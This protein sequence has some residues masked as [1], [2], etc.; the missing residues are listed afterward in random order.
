M[1]KSLI[2]WSL[3]VVEDIVVHLLAILL[4]MAPSS[5]VLVHDSCWMF[6]FYNREINVNQ[7]NFR[8]RIHEIVHIPKRVRL[9]LKL[10]RP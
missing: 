8:Y 10:I 6:L 3:V 4:S 1:I 9:V 2:T 7:L 5:L